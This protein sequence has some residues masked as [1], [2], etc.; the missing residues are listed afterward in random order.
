MTLARNACING[1]FT[2]FFA[3][4]YLIYIVHLVAVI[5]G[6]RSCALLAT[7]SQ[8]HFPVQVYEVDDDLE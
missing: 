7:A 1:R 3:S 8:I 4:E 2:M 5:L 6:V